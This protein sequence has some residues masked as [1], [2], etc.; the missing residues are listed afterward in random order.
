MFGKE[1]K[2][3]KNL[4]LIFSFLLIMGLNIHSN[5]KKSLT[6]FHAG[7][8]AKPFKEMKAEFEKENFNINVLLEAAGSIECVR[9]ITELKRRADVMASADEFVIRTYL[10]PDHAAWSVNFVTNEMVIMFTDKSK[11]GKEIN[12]ENWYKILLRK[13]V[14]YGHSEPNKDPCGYRALQTWQL[15]E[16]FYQ[17]KNLYKKLDDKCQPKNVR[18]KEVD[19]LA[20]LESGEIDYLFIYK[21]V[22]IQHN[23]KFIELP[24]EINLGSESLAQLYKK[25]EVEI[26]GKN[27]GEKVKHIGAPIVY[28][29]TVPLNAENR[30]LGEKFVEFLLSEKGKK[31]MENN[32]H[33]SINPATSAQFDILPESI[34]KYAKKL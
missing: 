29:V 25:A 17:E 32:G 10:M 1:K 30:E 9:K 24:K 21:S 23:A 14:E 15:A 22:A 28:S 18:P 5:K 12:S 3:K 19:M 4:L 16:I 26:N 11:F 6:I 7:S 27:P 20:H 2:M 31:I 33:P 34:K 8:L 13:G